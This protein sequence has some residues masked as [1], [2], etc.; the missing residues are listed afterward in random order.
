MGVSNNFTDW[1]KDKKDP[2]LGGTLTSEQ[3]CA[4]GQRI[5]S[6]CNQSVDSSLSAKLAWSLNMVLRKNK[7]M[8]TRIPHL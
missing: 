8:N 3:E 4:P 6:G 2:L 5:N 1:D 7:T